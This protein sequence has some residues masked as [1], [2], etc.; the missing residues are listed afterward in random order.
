M[1]AEILGQGESPAHTVYYQLLLFTL[2]LPPRS[3]V[4]QRQA[5]CVS[6][7]NGSPA[8]S[9]R[10]KHL[11]DTTVGVKGLVHTEASADQARTGSEELS[12]PPC[13]F[14][15]LCA[16]RQ[17]PLCPWPPSPGRPVPAAPS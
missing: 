1:R 7:M 4:P 15:P 2:C 5:G 10:S 8:P 11:M 6:L 17:D 12:V 3:S 14:E 9:M 16:V 13:V